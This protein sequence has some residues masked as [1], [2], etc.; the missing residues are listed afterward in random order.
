MHKLNPLPLSASHDA[1]H[2]L[3]GRQ[4]LIPTDTETNAR[5]IE[6][7]MLIGKGILVRHGLY[8]MVEKLYEDEWDG[9]LFPEGIEAMIKSAAVLAEY[10]PTFITMIVAPRERNHHSARILKEELSKHN[11]F[12]TAIEEEE[13]LTQRN[14]QECGQNL[15]ENLKLKG[16]SLIHPLLLVTSQPCIKKYSSY[17]FN[18][19][20]RANYGEGITAE[21]D[22][23][24]LE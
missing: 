18:E 2:I 23:I 7:R 4:G 10:L 13:L 3:V 24:R 5:T 1:N 20:F 6:F 11:V 22:I 14:F 17:F 21:G 15:W 8:R 9:E 19:G 12:V 16:H